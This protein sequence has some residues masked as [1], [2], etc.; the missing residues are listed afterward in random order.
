MMPRLI[1]IQIMLP[2]MPS[3][4]TDMDTDTCRGGQGGQGAGGLPGWVC[5]VY[6]QVL[7]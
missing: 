7:E 1:M 3:A 4:S 2:Q 5:R 6:V